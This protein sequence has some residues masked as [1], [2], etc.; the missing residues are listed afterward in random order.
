MTYSVGGTIQAADINSWLTTVNNIHGVGNGDR[1]YGQTT[2]SQPPV[3][4]G[5]TITGTQWG[6]L[7]NM[8][9]ACATHQGTSTSSLV[10]ATALYTGNVIY[11]HIDGAAPHNF[12]FSSVISAIDANRLAAFAGVMNLLTNAVVVTK[13]AAWNTTTTTIVDVT[14][15]SET[16][17]RYFFNTGGEIR[18]HLSATGALASSVTSQDADWKDIIYNKVGYISLKARATLQTA[19]TAGTVSNS[20]FYDLT[21][22]PTLIFDGTNIGGV[23]YTTNDVLITCAVLNVAGVNG[24]NGN[25]IRFT[26]TAKDDHT[27][28]NYDTVSAG[29]TVSFDTY[30]VGTGNFFTPIETPVYN[31]IQ[32][33]S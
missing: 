20:G 13:S 21:T 6:N 22:T 19:G 31:I 17:A 18:L 33:W 27:N 5:T 8:I 12:N 10:P 1:G 26:I 16:A 14:F 3:L 24:G 28:I 23:S 25:T 15:T 4:V 2:S 11:S 30:K 9:V 7:W 32:P 29:L